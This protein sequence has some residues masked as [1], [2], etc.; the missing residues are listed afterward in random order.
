[1]REIGARKKI[2]ITPVMTRALQKFDRKVKIVRMQ[3]TQERCPG[4][5]PTLNK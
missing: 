5:F 4:R 1:M 3:D 2:K